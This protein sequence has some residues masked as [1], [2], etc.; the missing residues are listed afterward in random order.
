MLALPFYF[1]LNTRPLQAFGEFFAH[2][3]LEKVLKTII[4]AD[5]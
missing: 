4:A 3:L 2:V 1:Y 5:F